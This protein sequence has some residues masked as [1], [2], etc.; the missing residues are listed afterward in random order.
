[1]SMRPLDPRSVVRCELELEGPMLHIACACGVEFSSLQATICGLPIAV[2]AC[3]SCG[4]E[5]VSDL[6]ISRQVLARFLPDLDFDSLHR[7]NTELDD[8]SQHWHRHPSW[9]EILSVE[10]A[11]LGPPMERELVAKLLKPILVEDRE[12]PR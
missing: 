11:D 4:V 7:L 2:H 3:P 5:T 6:E 12:A 10:G 9:R 8:L 1:M